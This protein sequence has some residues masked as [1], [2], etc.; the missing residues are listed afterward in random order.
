ML[1][2]GLVAA[3]LVVGLAALEAG[4]WLVHPPASSYPLPR[5]LMTAA[6]GVWTLS[7]GFQG[8]MDNRVDF[9]AKT[10]SV[11]D[12]GVRRAPAA[13]GEPP[14]RRLFV[15]GDSQTFGH[16]LNDDET[17]PARL[18]ALL[19][20]QTPG[21]RVE[22]WGVPGINIDQ[23][24]ARLDR[25]LAEARS[26]DIVL[27][28]VSWNDLI[29]P[30]NPAWA[31]RVIEGYLV[32]SAAG[33]AEAPAADARTAARVRLYDYTGI[34]VPPF[35]DIQHFAAMLA[36]NSALASFLVPR[37]RGLW[38]RWRPSTPLTQVVEGQ[39]PD[40]NFLLL[41]HMKER[42]EPRGVGFGVV[43]LPERYF[44][45]DAMYEAYSGGGRFFP[46][47]N[48]MN[49]LARPLCRSL[50][51]RCIDP[52]EALVSGHRREPVTFRVDGHYNARGAAI[53]ADVVAGQIGSLQP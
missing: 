9:R 47:R 49:Y 16:G 38:Q 15:L 20:A 40:V 30:Q 17:W 14:R 24:V 13:R 37:L 26:G 33:T 53:I 42:A 2:A 19:D 46:E 6:S 51:I 10:V 28:G 36:V 29:T 35:Q 39:V 3:S 23:Y 50:E 27:T 32:Q 5:N 25:V 44:I 8:V 31:M 48:Y 11:D 18:Q 43:L 34:V 7:P 12:R 41:R 45:D 52:F 1:H 21:T 4:M 22:N